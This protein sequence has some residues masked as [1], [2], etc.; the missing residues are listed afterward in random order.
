MG[1]MC[2]V[3]RHAVCPASPAAPSP[4][5]A[6]LGNTRALNQEWCPASAARK[7]DGAQWGAPLASQRLAMVHRQKEHAPHPGTDGAEVRH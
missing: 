1:M 2:A 4:S 7:G 3:L 5:P 6:C